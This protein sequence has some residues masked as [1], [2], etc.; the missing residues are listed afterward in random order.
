MTPS[1]PG[2]TPDLPPSPHPRP[3]LVP[4]ATVTQKSPAERLLGIP[5]VTSDPKPEKPARNKRGRSL[6]VTDPVTGTEW[7]RFDTDLPWGLHYGLGWQ[8]AHEIVANPAV[9]AEW[10]AR[11]ATEPDPGELS[12]LLSDVAGGQE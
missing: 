1:T 2:S 6:K 8:M 7:E 11:H 3:K 12:E 5:D 4:D 9:L 10:K